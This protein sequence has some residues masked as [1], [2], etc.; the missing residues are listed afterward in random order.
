MNRAAKGGVGA[1]TTYGLKNYAVKLF[2]QK[3]YCV[4]AV[5][6]VQEM[7]CWHTRRYNEGWDDYCSKC[8]NTGIYARHVLFCFTFSIGEKVFK[9]HQPEQYVDW[10][11]KISAEPVLYKQR[12][13]TETEIS[14]EDVQARQVWLYTYLLMEGV[15]DLPKLLGWTQAWK[16]DGRQIRIDVRH[17]VRMRIRRM[18]V[19][20]DVIQ[21][22]AS[23]N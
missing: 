16:A 9:W 3:G 14:E 2:Y 11:V 1:I 15:K 8:D 20:V 18:T 22:W 12:E 17:L 10:P 13:I 4:Q 7:E 21:R 19:I 23:K 6:S 5:K